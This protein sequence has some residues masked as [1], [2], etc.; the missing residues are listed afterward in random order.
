MLQTI[1]KSNLILGTLML[2]LAGVLTRIIGFFYRIF[3]SRQIGEEGMGIYQLLS[4]LM[5]LSFSFTCAGIQTSLSKHVAACEAENRHQKSIL[6]LFFAF[7][8]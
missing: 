8:I 1:R 5:A 3:L 4:P 6:T 2:T 7:F